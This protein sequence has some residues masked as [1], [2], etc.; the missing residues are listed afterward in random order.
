MYV[1]AQMRPI[2]TVPGIKG[3]GGRREVEGMNSSMMYLI[4]F[5][6]LY[7]C[8]NVPTPSTTIK[9][10]KMH[11]CSTVEV[12]LLQCGGLKLM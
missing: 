11:T 7:K 12:R 6:N 9:K 3:G 2:E 10:K 1:N 8:Y 4:H 5:K